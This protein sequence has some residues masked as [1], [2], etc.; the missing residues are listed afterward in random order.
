MR[1][2]WS[3]SVEDVF[4]D[5]SLKSVFEGTGDELN[6]LARLEYA[7]ERKAEALQAK[8][9]ISNVEKVPAV[10]ARGLSTN[11]VHDFTNQQ[12]ELGRL[13]RDAQLFKGAEI[14]KTDVLRSL[15][16][17]AKLD[18]TATYEAKHMYDKA[19]TDIG[20]KY[21]QY[22]GP[23]R[24]MYLR[25]L[26]GGVSK[27]GLAASDIS[28]EAAAQGITPEKAR[29]MDK[30]TYNPYENTRK[31]K[32]GTL[33]Y[34]GTSGPAVKIAG[35]ALMD[36]RLKATP[37]EMFEYNRYN[38]KATINARA[39]GTGYDAE[40]PENIAKYG[41]GSHEYTKTA[42]DPLFS[43]TNLNRSTPLGGTGT[44]MIPKGFNAAGD[45][46]GEDNDEMFLATDYKGYYGNLVDATQYSIGRAGAGV[47]DTVMDG[48]ARVYKEAVKQKSDSSW[49]GQDKTEKQA[50]A[51]IKAALPSFLGGYFDDNGN[52]VGLDDY[53]KPEEYGYQSNISGWTDDWKQTMGDPKSTVLD[54]ITKSL[55]GVLLAPEVIASSAGDM[56]LASTG[57]PGLVASAASMMN[58]TLE[59][60]A[61]IKGTTDLDASDYLIAGSAGAIYG[62]ANN[63]TKGMA[64]FKPAYTAALDAAKGLDNIALRALTNRLYRWVAEVGGSALEEG[65][66]EVI[67]GISEVVG[68]KYDTSKQGEILTKDTAYD[69]ATQGILGAAAGGVS[70]TA[71]L[72]FQD[73]DPKFARLQALKT[74]SE[75]LS[76]DPEVST[77]MYTLESDIATHDEQLNAINELKGKVAGFETVDDLAAAVNDLETNNSFGIGTVSSDENIHKSALAGDLDGTKEALIGRL[78]ALT[79]SVAEQREDK[80]FVYNDLTKKFS[81]EALPSVPVDKYTSIDDM[82][83]TDVD[84]IKANMLASLEGSTDPIVKAVSE[85]TTL[86]ELQNLD[87]SVKDV[88]ITTADLKPLNDMLADVKVTSGKGTVLTMLKR[89]FT[90]ASDVSDIKSNLTKTLANIP[91]ASLLKVANADF[92]NTISNSIVSEDNYKPLKPQFIAKQINNELTKRKIVDK[93][94]G[95]TDIKRMT[96]KDFNTTEF[97][98]IRKE[99]EEAAAD[100]SLDE[101]T[102][103]IIE[104]FANSLSQMTPSELKKHTDKSLLASLGIDTPVSYSSPI[105]DNKMVLNK[106]LIDTIKKAREVATKTNTLASWSAAD[107]RK[108]LAETLK[109]NAA[110]SMADIDIAETI[111]DQFNLSNLV[112]EAT[113]SNIKRKLDIIRNNSKKI[114]KEKKA[115]QKDKIASIRENLK[116]STA[117]NE[118]V[119]KNIDNLTDEQVTDLY[120]AMEIDENTIHL[121]KSLGVDFKEE[122]FGK[123]NIVTKTI[124]IKM[125]CK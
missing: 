103:G 112:N 14:A 102:S 47:L 5:I 55:E 35:D 31:Q 113:Y 91:T 81:G 16:P 79:Q 101:K 61:K 41:G 82:G 28:P 37:A 125:E 107:K 3:T 46:I 10:N 19:G 70:K 13:A 15:T 83:T 115:A 8:M 23:E 87:T 109:A 1:S 114:I 62:I 66:E 94:I 89:L 21:E 119:A 105:V 32:D 121:F 74:A 34:D 88:A 20:Y 118:T 56:I 40:T 110:E 68:Q 77:R 43:T 18:P 72:P 120:N 45:Y 80:S 44:P 64:G 38:D 76:A 24:N 73:V 63:F 67:Q 95:V 42:M 4:G 96:A 50:S 85:A 75:A 116:N 54:K 53:K 48:V 30:R 57:V 25:N 49:L 51:D 26:S 106:A 124:E 52:F 78:D 122:S 58:D 99:I 108:Y 33:G 6:K 100:G 7:A 60:R 36:M 104:K 97:G 12:E 59:A 90:D 69:L 17:G 71:N 11:T 84:T 92:I 65:V 22:F 111:L 2:D 86:E 93:F 29:Y 98:D 117:I 27:L 123:E 39:M 9:K